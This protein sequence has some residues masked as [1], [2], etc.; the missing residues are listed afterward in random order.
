MKNEEFVKAIG[1]SLVI[2]LLAG[3]TEYLF[4]I[5]DGKIMLRYIFEHFVCF[6]DIGISSK[7]I[8]NCFY[9]T[10]LSAMIVELV[11]HRLKFAKLMIFIFALAGLTFIVTLV[12][13]NVVVDFIAA[14]LALIFCY[15]C[16]HFLFY[17]ND[18]E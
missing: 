12:T 6:P 2:S 16:F 8:V 4:S 14:C 7:T 3:M 13:D 9:P 15:F 18:E 17:R 1:V 10:L 11:N 5:I